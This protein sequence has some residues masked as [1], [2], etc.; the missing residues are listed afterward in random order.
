MACACKPLSKFTTFLQQA[1]W[2][3]DTEYYV[4]ANFSGCKYFWDLL[5]SRTTSS[6]S[7]IY[8]LATTQPPQHWHDFQWSSEP[9]KGAGF[10]VGGKSISLS[11]PLE[12]AAVLTWV[13]HCAH[14]NTIFHA[15]WK[16]LFACHFT[17]WSN[18]R[19]TLPMPLATVEHDA[20]QT[21]LQGPKGTDRPWIECSESSSKS[22]RRQV[23]ETSQFTRHKWY[24]RSLHV[25]D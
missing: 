20:S 13:G 7:W 21:H 11:Q 24:V 10:H 8:V 23:S 14:Q 6:L 5:G 15:I 17:F 12:Q 4:E 16:S 19:F 9:Q 3:E 1:P 25:L 2:N 18:P 22:L